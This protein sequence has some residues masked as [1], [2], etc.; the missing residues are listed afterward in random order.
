[1]LMPSEI[2]TCLVDIPEKRDNVAF[3]NQEK[4]AR[5]APTKQLRELSENYEHNI[6]ALAAGNERGRG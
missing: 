2:Q 3:T 5:F 4:S 6:D 1:M